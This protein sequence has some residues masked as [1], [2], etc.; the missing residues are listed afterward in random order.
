MSHLLHKRNKSLHLQLMR[1]ES[2]WNGYYR[3]GC[4]MTQTSFPQ[5]CSRLQS[6]RPRGSADISPCDLLRKQHRHPGLAPPGWKI[7]LGTVGIYRIRGFW[8]S[9]KM[10]VSE[11]AELWA[12]LSSCRE[13]GQQKNQEIGPNQCSGQDRTQL[14]TG[15]GKAVS[16]PMV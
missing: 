14:P 16:T 6:D 10:Q 1:S 12:E 9:C 4:G 13:V 3:W 2:F 11:T 7:P 15:K 5:R 8:G